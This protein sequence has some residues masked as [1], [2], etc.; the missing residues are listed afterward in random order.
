MIRRAWRAVVG[1]LTSA[2]LAVGLLVF[3]GAWSM[4]STFIPQGVASVQKVAAWATAYPLLEPVVRA[5]GLHQAFTS[6]LFTVGILLLAVSTA[7]CS[8]RRTKAAIGRARTLRKADRADQRSIAE[9]HDCEIACDPVLS[10]PEILS[11]ATETLGRLGIKAK[12]HDDVIG[13]VSS[14]WSV[15]GSPVFH[16][17]LVALIVLVLVGTLQRSDGLMGLAVGQTKA[18]APASYGALTAGPL[19]DWSS[20]HRSIRVEAFDPDYQTGGIDRGPAPTV[21]VLD[22]AGSV[23]KTQLVYPNM[24]LH[25]GS[26]SI[27]APTYGLATTLSLVD[28]SGA[29]IGRSIQLADFSDTTTAGTTP[30]G[31]ITISDSAGN[32]VLRCYVTVPL[33]RSGGYFVERVPANVTAR[34]VV[35]SSDGVQVLDRTVK[36]GEDVELPT[37]GSLRLI[38]IGYYARLSI[39]DDATVPFIY[40]AMV[41]AMIGLGSTVFFRQRMVVAAVVE[42]PDGAKLALR[43]RLWRNTSTN[44]SEIESALVQ[45]LGGDEKG[46]MS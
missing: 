17:A 31:F 32:A 26:L 46:S 12:R 4:L 2:G 16:W 23:I 5:L 21:S 33:D 18:D 44:R 19:H 27:N 41:I 9:T 22:A 10:G 43:M 38:G 24:M 14:S 36:Q 6:P 15:W 11:I 35:T 1:L 7:L 30:A 42:G 34:V 40:A 29:E 39:V 28:T 3:V 25:V 20:V 37:G 45:A 8:W 13:A